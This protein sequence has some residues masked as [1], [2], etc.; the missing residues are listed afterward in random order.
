MTQRSPFRYFKTFPKAIRLAVM[1]YVRVPLSLR[2]VEDLLHE[3]GIEVGLCCKEPGSL[4]EG[5]LRLASTR[6]TDAAETGPGPTS[7]GEARVGQRSTAGKPRGRLVT[8]PSLRL[9]SDD[10]AA[11][12]LDAPQTMVALTYK[13]LH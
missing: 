4:Q 2:N 12:S 6:T 10:C 13:C 8:C 5:D 11:G 3:R 9:S 7:T 1:L